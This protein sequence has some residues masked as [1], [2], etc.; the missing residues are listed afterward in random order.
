[1]R[2]SKWVAVAASVLI[3]GAPVL[4][5]EAKR[6]GGGFNIGRTAPSPTRAA[7]TAVPPKPAAQ[8]QT[9]PQ[10]QNAQAAKAAPAAPAAAQA[11]RSSW[12]GPLA[13]LAA[14]L[15][16]AALASYLGFGEELMSLMLIALAVMVGVVVIRMIMGRRQAPAGSFTQPAMARSGYGNQELGAEARPSNSGW[17]QQGSGSGGGFLG[18]TAET[19]AS[20]PVVE[21][22]SPAEVENFL[23][24]AR[25]Q[26]TQLQTI[27][28]SGDIN[29]LADFCT[30]EMT[31]ELSHQIAGRRGTANQ[32]QVLSLDATWLGMAQGVDDFGKPVDEVRIQFSGLIR[33]SA[34][35]PPADF[36]EIWTLHR[37]LQGAKSGWLL[38]G[39]AQVG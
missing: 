37:P 27:W 25:E 8:P 34:D 38:A 16:L 20:A 2:A 22:V 31:R 3:F 7:P 32:T 19:A 39:I 29:T 28:D 35:A 13:G 17:S 6:L 18:E 10:G 11:G 12:M 1:V 14:G 33:E 26:F 4:E 9:A 30:P 36:D 21:E 24:A 5:A 15:G 23:K